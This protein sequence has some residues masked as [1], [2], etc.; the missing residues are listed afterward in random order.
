MIYLDHAATTACSAEVVDA[1]VPYLRE[2]FANASSIDHLPGVMAR[3]AVDEAREAVALLVGARAEDVIFTSGSTE[4]NNLAMT[5]ACPVLTTQIEHPS[6]LDSFTARNMKT[7]RFIPVDEH[8]VVKTEL[9]EEQL[10]KLDDRSLVSIIATNNETGTEQDIE[11]LLALASDR[12]ALLHVDA[13]QAVGTRQFGARREGLAALSISAHKIHGPKGVGALI[14]MPAM[15][16]QLKP[17]LRGGGH[18]RG[19]RSGTL[20]VPGIVGFG[21]AARIIRASWLTRRERLAELR[22]QFLDKLRRLSGDAVRETIPGTLASPHILS[23]RM[24]G[25]NSRALLGAVREDVAFS[26]GSACATNKAEPSH[27]LVALGL[28]KRAVAETFRISFSPDQ[29]V[30]QIEAAATILASAAA[31]LSGYSVP[32]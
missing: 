2:Q 23:V 26:L 5:V 28:D 16:A 17:V 1:M 3:R 11:R 9:L 24:L 29:S 21:V 19:L 30:E 10:A 31:T 8:G 4:A 12:G 13:T 22:Q 20:N 32:A 25:T 18:E 14:A 6:I 7:D 27:V 15:R